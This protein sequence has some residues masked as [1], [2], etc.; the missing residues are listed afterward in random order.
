MGCLVTNVIELPEQP[1]YP[2]AIVAISP[3]LNRI[4]DINLAD[5]PRPTQLSLEVA[6]RDVNVRQDLEYLVFVNFN[7]GVGG[8]ANK[9]G[10]IEASSTADETN[11][12]RLKKFDIDV[13]DLGEPGTC[14]KIEILVSGK[15]DGLEFRRPE[16]PGDI[17]SAVWWVDVRDGNSS[18]TSLESCQ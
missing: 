13:S 8:R 15:F 2:P 1:N 6:V 11:F 16:I 5:D 9:S 10:T 12:E 3:P 7:S 4:I 17:D 18:M 14:K